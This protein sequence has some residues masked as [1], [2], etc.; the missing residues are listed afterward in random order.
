[1]GGKVA[2]EKGD[3]GWYNYGLLHQGKHE[4]P[5]RATLHLHTAGLTSSDHLYL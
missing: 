3:W 2:Q 4:R 1:M 5:N